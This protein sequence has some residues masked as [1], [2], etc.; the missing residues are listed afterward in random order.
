MTAE[1]QSPA[2]QSIREEPVPDGVV[3]TGSF[4][5][6]DG[7][8]KGAVDVVITADLGEFAVREFA[9]TQE[10]LG[11]R[12]P[13]GRSATEPC[14][15]GGGFAFPDIV[16]GTPSGP[17]I[18][19]LSFGRGDPTFITEIVLTT[20]AAPDDAQSCIDRVTARAPIE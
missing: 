3:A 14:V 10:R 13:F 19:P 4:T 16:A 9:T 1:A 12:A 20:P 11:V 8:T 18:M 7:S 17:L 6:T 2:A 15:G 5:S